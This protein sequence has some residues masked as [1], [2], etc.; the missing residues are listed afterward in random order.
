[1]VTFAHDVNDV[2][3]HIV[4]QHVMILGGCNVALLRCCRI[5]LKRHQS[6][7]EDPV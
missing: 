2:N 3:T 1:M 7:F 5:R 4:S 6:E